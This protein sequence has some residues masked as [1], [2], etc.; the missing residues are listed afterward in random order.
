LL[1]KSFLGINLIRQN[2]Y[3]ESKTAILKGESWKKPKS[4]EIK[5][6]EKKEAK[7]INLS[8]FLIMPSSITLC[9]KFFIPKQNI[10]K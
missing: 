10:H 7:T 4:I 5:F 3:S 9:Y 2:K 8:N 6:A 1:M